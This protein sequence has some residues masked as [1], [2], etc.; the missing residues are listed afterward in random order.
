MN[1]REALTMVLRSRELLYAML[2]R[3]FGGEPDEAMIDVLSSTEFDQVCAVLD[4]DK[5]T[6]SSLRADIGSEVAERGL[7]E[8]RREYT[9]C[10]VGPQT[11]V[12]PWESVYVTGEELV[13]QPCTL[14]VRDAYRLEGFEANGESHEPDDHVATEADFLAKLARRATGEFESAEAGAALATLEA[15]RAFLLEHLGAWI[16]DFSNAL[17]SAGPD[18][19]V[20]WRIARFA[21]AFVENDKALLEEFIETIA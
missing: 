15:S 9:V 11:L 3:C 21:V 20:Y 5:G 18:G 10:F 7:E 19:E 16:V 2:S 8:L 12:F 14:N 6:L 4:D 13:F 17:E 1:E